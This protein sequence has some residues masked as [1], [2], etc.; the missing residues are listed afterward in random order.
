MS[1]SM[2]TAT[3]GS[4][5][6][7]FFIF[8]NVVVVPISIGAAFDI[9]AY[10]V[11]TIQRSSFIFTGIACILQGVWGHRYPIMEGPSGVIWGL[12]LNLCFS[13]S[14][15]GMSLEEIGGGIATGMILAGIF[16]MILAIFN[17]FPLI[18]KILTPTV[19]SVYLFLL[20]FQLVFTFFTGM[21]KINDNGK[22]DLPISLF[23][24]VIVIFVCL[25]NILGK[26]AISN[27]SI[28]IG[29]IVGWIGYD[30]LFPE[31][32]AMA[33][34]AS[35]LTLFPFGQPNLQVSIILITFLGCLV[36][37][38]NTRT[39]VEATSKILNETASSHQYK[40][41]YLLTGLYA[42]LAPVFGLIS[43]S[44]YASSIGFLESTKMVN[45]RPFLV[46]G[47]LM[48]LLGIIPALGSLLATLPITVGN[49]VLFVAYLQLFGTSIKSLNGYQFSS[50][51][52]YRLAIPILVGVSIMTLDSE[53][54]TSLPI[55]LQPLFGNGFIVGVLLSV[56][57]EKL[58][59]WDKVV[60]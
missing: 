48:V 57:I 1:K 16:T 8:A 33:S 4:I 24:I 42:A 32:I 47:G 17:L 25:L 18:N 45:K 6:W 20:T 39:T 54:F 52:I 56:F 5:Q 55:Y 27:F 51:T 53:V 28:L 38:S 7:L 43:Y 10:E 14:S 12:V 26:K 2:I 36:N 22:L 15:L 11:A 59:K 40:S 50:K 37:L 30:L 31:N 19:M 21:L 34:K 41:S 60:D 29:M 49:A 3:F 46:G 35:S 44:P 23:S 9:P 58:I 13:A